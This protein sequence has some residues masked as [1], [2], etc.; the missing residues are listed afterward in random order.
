MNN[1]IKV[2]IQGVAGAFHDTAA[3]EYFK[4][5]NIEIVPC[6]TFEDLFALLDKGGCDYGVVAAENSVA[7]ILSHN[8]FLLNEYSMQIVGEHYLRIV[9]NLMVLPGTSIDKVREVRSHPIALR[10][11]HLFLNGL[12]S[13]DVM[14]AESEDTALS[15]KIIRDNQLVGVAAVAG[16]LAA[17]LYG[18]EIIQAGIESNPRNFTRFLVIKKRAGTLDRAIFKTGENNKAS[19][20]FTLRHEPGM[21]CKVL[22]IFSNHNL[23]MTMI[24]SLPLPGKEWE[25]KFFADFVF[26]ESLACEQALEEVGTATGSVTLSGLYRRGETSMQPFEQDCDRQK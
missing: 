2:A 18:L 3:R 9:Q 10:Q 1:I 26:E 21:L 19:V 23:N 5:Q 16:E 6:I 24:Q 11:C 7:G 15:A 13:K 8:F 4:G 20:S 14:I 25:Y 12:R 17:K 22:S